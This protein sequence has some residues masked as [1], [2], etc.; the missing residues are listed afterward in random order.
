MKRRYLKILLP[1]TLGS[2]LLFL[3][4]LRDLHF[5]SAFLASIIGCFLAA[6][7]LAK[8]KKTGPSFRLAIGIMGYIYFIAVPLF[9][10]SLITGCLTFDGFAFWIL[11][12]APSVFF[13]A[14]IGR[15]VSKFHFPKPIVVSLAILIFCSLGVWMI[16]FFT[17]PQVY[18]FNHVWG[19]WPGPIYDETLRVTESLLFFRWIT[20]LWIIL[21]WILPNWS[22]TTQNRIV[23]FLA[24]G[25]LIFSYLNLDEMGIITPRETLKKELSAHY[26]TAHFDLYFEENNFTDQEMEYWALRH[27]FHFQQIITFLEI[28]WPEGRK[29]ESY[30]YANAWQ[31]K[32][33]VGAKFTSYVPI[34]LEQ[35]Q[36]HI[37]K[38][39]LEGVLKHELV[40]V[41]SKQFGNSLFNGSWSI[42]MIEGI[43]E[44]VAKDASPQSTLDQIISAEQTYPTSQQMKDAL[45][46]SG[47]YS[48]ASSISYTTAGSFVQFLL[49]NYPIE[50]FK[51]AYPSNDFEN[52][53]PVSFEELVD[54]WHQHLKTTEIDSV[55]KQISEF[56]FSRRSLFQ[57]HCPHAFT[58]EQQLWDDYNF[59]VSNRD[60]VKA[61]KAIE[62]LYELNPNNKLIKRD[63]L[64]EQL[65]HR[66][67]AT[68]LYEF[69]PSDSLLTLQILKVDALFLNGDVNTAQEVLEEI[70]PDIESSGSRTFKYSYELRSDSLN[71]STFLASRYNNKI[72]LYEVFSNLKYPSKILI[73][74]KAIE[75]GLLKDLKRMI[76]SQLLKEELNPDW[77]EIYENTI[78]Q[79]VFVNS[80]EKADLL[81]DSLEH[82]SLRDRYKE[83]L[84]E[85]KE[86]RNFVYSKSTT[87]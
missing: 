40:H 33:L 28:D 44:S 82:I 1:L 75:L 36:L 80:F 58:E 70:K 81:I 25:C 39:H 38:Q 8:N 27:E 53:Y 84:S 64:R 10:S 48:S 77:F 59:H 21:L 54:G 49:N 74:S 4:L 45:S 30:I 56:I 14:S 50:N 85:L 52:S 20:I 29:V 62:R 72:P 73:I 42:G 16:E 18:F 61:L 2:L 19:T 31:K 46:N 78:D 51:K 60:S 5:E 6:I 17:L 37:A 76:T 66:N 47:F 57:K 68:T 83:R 34:W 69:D 86:W 87:N 12:P 11:L 7:V 35:D 71:W 9:I 43:A 22:E 23:T 67:Y 3:P 65:L 79:L 63:W 41:I 13:G 24:L 15:I 32:E 26:Q 55:D